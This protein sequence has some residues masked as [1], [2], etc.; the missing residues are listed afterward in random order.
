M[1]L[2]LFLNII[3]TFFFRKN[4]NIKTATQS[5]HLTRDFGFGSSYIFF[6]HSNFTFG[7]DV[8]YI[9]LQM[10]NFICLIVW[11]TKLCYFCFFLSVSQ[12]HY[13]GR[14]HTAEH[15]PNGPADPTVLL[16]HCWWS[17]VFCYWSGVFLLT[18]ERSYIPPKLFTTVFCFQLYLIFVPFFYVSSRPP[19]TWKQCCRQ[20]GYWLLL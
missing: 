8:S 6:I 5:C 15:G 18:G 14:I 19:I 10:L 7:P 2:F 9:Y 20:A 12:V 16:H 1:K 13:W 3:L 4:F 11:K 17:D